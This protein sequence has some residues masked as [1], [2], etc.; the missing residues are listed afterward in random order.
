VPVIR[1]ALRGL[2]KTR[3]SLF[4]GCCPKPIPLTEKNF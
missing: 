3:S 1:E 4:N 2:E